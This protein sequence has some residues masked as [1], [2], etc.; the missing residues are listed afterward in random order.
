MQI[1]RDLWVKLIGAGVQA[2]SGDNSQPWKFL[3][4]D[5][6]LRIYSV[7]ERDNPAYNLDQK[8]SLVAIGAL[9]ENISISASVFGYSVEV[10]S[11]PALEENNTIADLRLVSSDCKSDDLVSYI[12]SRCTNRKPYNEEPIKEEYLNEILHVGNNFPDAE[13]KFVQNSSE[14][15][16]LAQAASINERVVLENFLLHQYFFKHICWTDKEEEQKRA[17]LFLKTLEFDKP[18]NL[19]FHLFKNWYIMNLFNKIGFARLVAATNAKIY[20]RSAAVGLISLKNDTKE[21]YIQA[22]RQLQRIW[23]TVEKCGLSFQMITGIL[24]FMHRIR[25]AKVD[26]FFTKKHSDAIMTANSTIVD[27]FKINNTTPVLMFRIG[28]GGRPSGN[29]SRLSPEIIFM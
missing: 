28:N 12:N 13:F 10:T 17:G 22:G 18:T 4:K 29:S 14:V 7:P 15:T 21:S 2:P 25:A 20:S 1:E 19:F 9:I 24:Y 16:R 8:G 26:S 23:L 27:I 11:F 5:G 6:V 3:I